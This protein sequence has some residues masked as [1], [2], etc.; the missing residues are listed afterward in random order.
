LPVGGSAS[1]GAAST[2][3]ASESVVSASLRMGVSSL[4]AGRSLIVPTPLQPEARAKV[5][6]PRGRAQVIS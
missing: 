3:L 6:R 4:K 2:R 5:A 1:A